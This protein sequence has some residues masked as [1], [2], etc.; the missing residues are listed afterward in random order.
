MPYG[1]TSSLPRCPLVPRRW[2][3]RGICS[4]PL[5]LATGCRREENDPQV[6]DPADLDRIKLGDVVRLSELLKEPAE[7]V[8]L[9]RPYRD[10]LMHTEPLSDQVNA[11]LKQKGIW[12]D[13]GEFALVYVDGDK[14]TVQRL[15]APRHALVGW[16]EGAGRLV[17]ELGCSTPDRILVTR[18][19]DLW[20]ML[21]FGEQR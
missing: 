6:I 21:V 3:C 18:V 4:I 16:H 15:L 13:E 1:G 12:L 17:K 19:H 10:R 20:P 2:L 14:V 11:Y 5:A 7:K 9:L 8:C